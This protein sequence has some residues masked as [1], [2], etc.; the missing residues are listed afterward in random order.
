MNKYCFILL[1]LTKIK[2]VSEIS[3]V[4]WFQEHLTAVPLKKRLASATKSTSFF[5]LY[6]LIIS[7]CRMNILYPVKKNYYIS[8]FNESKHLYF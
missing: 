4:L 6:H 7:T 2:F 8:A 5:K 1:L 3:I